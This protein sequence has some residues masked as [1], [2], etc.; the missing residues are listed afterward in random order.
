[1][2][3]PEPLS[4]DGWRR[5]RGLAFGFDLF[6]R[7]FYWEAHE[8]WESAWQIT[9]EGA[10]RELL[11]G[12][13]QL[14][15]ARLRVEIGVGDG[16]A[17]LRDR[18]AGHLRAAAEQAGRPIVCGVWTDDVI[19]GGEL[20]WYRRSRDLP[21]VRTELLVQPLECVFAAEPGAIVQRTPGF[22]DYYGGRA[23]Y[24]DDGF[25]VEPARAA[26][27]AALEIDGPGFVNL[28]WEIEEPGPA[29]IELREGDEL[30]HLVVLCGRRLA[31][32]PARP[33]GIELRRIEGDA[34]WARAADFA[35]RLAVIQWGAGARS[36][37]DWRYRHY[38]ATVELCGGG[39]FA[40]MSGG[41]VV[42]CLG[43][44]DCGD[45]YRYQDVQVAPSHRRR[46]VANHLCAAAFEAVGAGSDR[47]AIIVAEAG[48]VAEG[49]YRRLGFEPVS[50]KH[51]LRWLLTEP[52][53]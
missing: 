11:R 8:V 3:P 15:A 34:D 52:G 17:R 22:Q 24:D 36:Y 32:S 45:V 1:M 44:I 50:T 53:T 16:A 29:E 6:E 31:R 5:H 37:T 39:F 23:Y 42:G 10:A 33:D 46:G 13:I 7:G 30:D 51:Y 48:A 38:R 2:P 9:G 35:G 25:D 27:E 18:A 28:V 4:L 47:P 14:A 26:T 12:L 43:V 19:A 20:R 41:E 49:M 40:A 21:G